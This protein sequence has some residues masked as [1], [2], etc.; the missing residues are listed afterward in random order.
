MRIALFT[1]D[2]PHWKT[3][4]FLHELC[5]LGC[6]PEAVIAAPWRTL[7]VPPSAVRGVRHLPRHPEALAE[8]YGI[9]YRVEPHDAIDDEYDLG[10]IGGARIIPR[11]TIDRFSIGILNMHP[12]LIPENRGLSNIARAIRDGLPQAVTAHLIDERV[13][14]GRVLFSE[15]VPVEPADTIQDVA[16]VMLDKQ[17]EMLGNA[18]GSIATGARGRAIPPNCGGYEP[19]LDPA[20]ETGILMRAGL[21]R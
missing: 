8:R 13:D 11:E 10:V 14:A 19:P 1:Y 21:L 15:E 2:R 4:R 16:E 18:I 20:T 3:E 17:A 7:N 6:K 12:G 5:S 9:E